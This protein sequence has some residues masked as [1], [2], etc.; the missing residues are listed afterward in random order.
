MRLIASELIA[1]EL[2]ANDRAPNIKSVPIC[3]REITHGITDR[4]YY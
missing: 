1:S 2:I 3:P 4:F